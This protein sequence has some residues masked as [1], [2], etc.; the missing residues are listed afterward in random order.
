MAATL[1]RSH[2]ALSAG[3]FLCGVIIAF[4]SVVD[5]EDERDTKQLTGTIQKG[6][7]AGQSWAFD[8]SHA[9]LRWCPPGEFIVG[10]SAK[11]KERDSDERQRKEVLTQGFWIGECEITQSEYKR[12][13]GRTVEDQH[14]ETYSKWSLGMIGDNYPMVYVSHEEAQLFCDVLTIQGQK[15]GALSGTWNYRLPTEVQWE[16]ACRAGTSTATSFGDSLSSNDANFDGSEPY[17][18]AAKGPDLGAITNVRSYKSNPWG[19]YDMHGNVWEWCEDA[20]VPDV[21]AKRKPS[22]QARDV[23]TFRGG[24]F[25]STGGTC[26]SASRSWNISSYRNDSL[27]F[28]VILVQS[29]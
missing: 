23:R 7:F 17:G 4:I 25:H 20:Y 21:T 2:N 13:M 16:Y 15:T 29:R 10:S 1:L 11:E 26:R 8:E 3:T 6:Q 24:G 19:I 22:K 9:P 14:R 12:V 18:S 5:A 27:G 28:R